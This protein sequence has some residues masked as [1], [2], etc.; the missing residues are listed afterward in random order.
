MDGEVWR[1]LN[2]DS[3]LVASDVAKR[4][5]DFRETIS[6]EDFFEAFS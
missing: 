4:D 3:R 1:G 6:D 5:C 2:A